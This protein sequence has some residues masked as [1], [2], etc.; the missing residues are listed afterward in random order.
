[1]PL[2]P[3]RSPLERVVGRIAGSAPFAAVAPKFVPPLDRFLYRISGGRILLSQALLPGLVLATTG[4][5]SGERRIVPL[6][7]LPEG[8]DFLVVGSNF[9]RPTH[10]AWTT[11]LSAVSGTCES[12]D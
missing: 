9:G 7:T 11:N 6:A 10:P 4:H 12:F 5:S 8:A 2:V 1:M 3:S